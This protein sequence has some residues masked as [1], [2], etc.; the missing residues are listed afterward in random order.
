[1]QHATNTH[2]LTPAAFSRIAA[3]LFVLAG[4]GL[5]TC[6]FS[7]CG[8]AQPDNNGPADE[9][10][11]P[12][13]VIASGGPVARVPLKKVAEFA[14]YQ[15]TGVT[16]RADGKVI[17]SAPRWHSTFVGPSVALLTG[18]TQ[19]SLRPLPDAEWNS[20]S[21]SLSPG[22]E[23]ETDLHAAAKAMAAGAENLLTKWVCVQSVYTDRTGR[24]WVLDPASPGITGVVRDSA[25]NGPKLVELSASGS[26]VVRTIAFDAAVAPEKSYL[27]D[28]RIDVAANIAYLSDS[29]LG[30]IVIVNLADGT[31]RRVLD[32]HPSVLAEDGVVPKV[33]GQE[34]RV[35]GAADGPV[36][37][38]NSDGIALDEV[39]GYLYWQP[40]TGRSLHR[41]R[42]KVLADAARTPA[43]LAEAIETVMP[44]VVT[45]GMEVDVKGNIFFTALE[46]DAVVMRIPDGRLIP[47]AGGPELAWPDSL[48]FGPGGTMY[49]SSSRIHRSAW[50]A[51]AD[52]MPTAGCGSAIFK[53]TLP[54]SVTKLPMKP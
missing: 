4:T 33:Q 19:D 24:I 5:V 22:A 49:V 7:G 3:A 52:A 20:L 35:G 39:R 1:M 31:A 51:A 38:I 2:G 46:Q 15:A 36:L 32:G 54:A 25:G 40:L 48:A 13:T 27:N 26:Q 28:V 6:F 9:S 34:L 14:T 18:S 21:L 53:L 44:S 42:T 30:G 10:R 41:M 29:G 8:T 50:F 12:L 17:V 23:A 45:D 47:L 11:G 37:K 16:V 43:E